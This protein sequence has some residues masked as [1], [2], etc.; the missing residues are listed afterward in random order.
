MHAF[1]SFLHFALQTW[2]LTVLSSAARSRSSV[3]QVLFDIWHACLGWPRLGQSE[4]N[5]VRSITIRYLGHALQVLG[6][7][8]GLIRSH[9]ISFPNSDNWL[10]PDL[11]AALVPGLESGPY[12]LDAC[13]LPVAHGGHLSTYTLHLEV[14]GGAWRSTPLTLPSFTGIARGTRF[15]VAHPGWH[16]HVSAMRQNHHHHHQQQRGGGG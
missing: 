6:C 2:L 3:V 9:L 1:S 12:G 7:P 4:P 13:A 15:T 16:E 14:L 11:A 8:W 5:T 10:G